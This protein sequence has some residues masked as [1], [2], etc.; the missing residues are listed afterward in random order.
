MGKQY[1]G[2]SRRTIWQLGL[3]SGCLLAVTLTIVACGSNMSGTTASGMGTVTVSLSDP[4]TCQVPSGPYSAVWVTVS[5]VDANISSTA[6]N[7]DSGWTPLT[8]KGMAPQQIN[9]LGTANTQC[10]LASLGDGTQLQAGT[11]QQI[12]L[13]LATSYSGSNNPCGGTAANCVVVGGTSTTN[14]TPYP[15]LLSSEAQTGIKIPASHISGGGFT[16]KAGQAEDLDIDFQ[17]CVSIVEEGNHQYRLKPVLTAGE[18][19]PQTDTMNGKVVDAENDYS[20]V[21]VTLEQVSTAADGTQVDRIILGPKL[22]NSDGTWTICPVLTTVTG[23]TSSSTFDVVISGSDKAGLIPYTPVIIT[24]VGIGDAVGSSSAPLQ[25]TLATAS[26]TV[27]GTF[28]SSGTSGAVPIDVLTSLLVSVPGSTTS[29]WYTVPLPMIGTTQTTAEPTF[30][31]APGTT[32]VPCSPT[33]GV[34]CYTYSLMAAPDN[35]YIVPWSA[36]ITLPTTPTPATYEVDGISSASNACSTSEQITKSGM[37][38]AT[39]PF[40]VNLGTLSYTGCTANA[41]P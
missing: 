14:G 27:T 9:L 41:T 36:A 22:V 29:P 3:V 11:Y 23:A 39:S 26:A 28:N 15:L 5:E 2:V 1:L 10:L 31:T 7:S 19:S 38:S 32:A 37:V 35:A 18:V 40:M 30:T 8:P 20:H 17:T 34:D 24:G 12:R 13:I 25:L 21:T 6:S 16:V 33:T 4:A